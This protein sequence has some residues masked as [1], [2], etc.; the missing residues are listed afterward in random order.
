MI[1]L[2]QIRMGAVSVAAVI[3]SPIAD[4]ASGSNTTADGYTFLAEDYILLTAQTSSIE[5]GI[6]IHAG[7]SLTRPTVAN[8]RAGESMLIGAEVYVLNG[9][10]NATDRFVLT[11]SDGSASTYGG[12][13]CVIGT[14]T[15]V[16]QN[17]NDLIGVITGPT[18]PTGPA[19]AD[20]TVAGPTGPTGPA[21]ADSTVA[22]PTGPTGPAGADSTVAG[23]TGPTGPAGADSTVAGPTG[24]TGPTG[25]AGADG[26]GSI[27]FSFGDGVNAIVAADAPDLVIPYADR[28]A[29]ASAWYVEGQGGTGSCEIDV[30]VGASG[31]ESSI[32][33]TEKPT[34][35]ASTA[36]S[37][38]TL[39]SWAAISAGDRIT[40]QLSSS[41]TFKYITGKIIY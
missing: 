37:D 1:H 24:T 15:Q 8:L 38:A 32:A 40:L 36:G 16:W 19:G 4:L 7:G 11:G 13:E 3:Q 9:T 25:P 30:L 6:Y 33:G 27:S 31:S 5:N 20:S 12:I 21:G 23:P 29:T 14:N 35:S 28:A 2:S 22:G 26:A 10:D 41:S 17:R 34:I 39:T 18:G